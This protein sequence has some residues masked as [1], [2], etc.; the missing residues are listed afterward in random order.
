MT[1]L[2]IVARV[3][4]LT[5][6]FS[7]AIFRGPDIEAFINEAIERVGQVVPE[8]EGMLPL[9]AASDSPILLPSRYHQLIAV[10]AA[11]RCFG[12]DER[13]YQNTQFMNEFEVKLDELKGKIQNGEVIIK[14]ATGAVVVADVA[15]DY[16]E[17][18]YFTKRLNIVDLDDGVEGV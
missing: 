1:R 13:H 5:R 6:D 2:E 11:A 15:F 14:D 3:R 16:V 12:Q 8:L 10:Y 7:N 17:D 4:A 9:N 18:N